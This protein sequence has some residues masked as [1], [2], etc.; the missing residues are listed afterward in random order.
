MVYISST[1]ELWKY[2]VGCFEGT[3]MPQTLKISDDITFR[4]V[5]RGKTW[6]GLIDY[7]IATFAES[8]QNAANTLAE[9]I[10][11]ISPEVNSA[12]RS[13]PIIIK[14]K[15]E[16]GSTD[17]IAKYGKQIIKRIGTLPNS[18]I[19]FLIT[20]SILAVSFVGF[21]NVYY[22]YR[23]KAMLA[24]VEKA[25]IQ[26]NT[27]TAELMSRLIDSTNRI[28]NAGERPYRDI[29]RLM[30]K[31]DRVKFG[32][33]NQYLSVGDAR[34]LFPRKDHPT[35]TTYYIDE[36]YEIEEVRQTK[37]K[38]KL[39]NK[40]I[41]IVASIADLNEYDIKKLYSVLENAKL[42][43]RPAFLNL[44]VNTRTK[45]GKAYNPRVIGI[46]YKRDGY[47]CITNVF[48]SNKEEK[49]KPANDYPLLDYIEANKR[50]TPSP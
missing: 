18:H 5:V 9:E 30:N 20:S 50:K 16:K 8:L 15:I 21:S 31:G 3:T 44:Q 11:Y 14:S 29:A 39:S 10:G 41:S 2:A 35:S 19:T 42:E 4:A 38:L 6:D 47:S 46:G 28:V 36:L 34:S 26:N 1:A 43:G 27:K 17:L 23:S 40:G 13:E 45:S 33:S 12:L 7:R 37:D 22:D 48:R 32:S 49:L 24:E 25:K